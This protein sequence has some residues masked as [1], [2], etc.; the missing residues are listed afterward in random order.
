MMN[1]GMCL[2][3]CYTDVPKVAGINNKFNKTIYKAS[4]PRVAKRSEND[5]TNNNRGM[6]AKNKRETTT[7]QSLQLEPR[8]IAKAGL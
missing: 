4:F 2:P 1:Y 5:K 6:R 3:K 7:R 8:K